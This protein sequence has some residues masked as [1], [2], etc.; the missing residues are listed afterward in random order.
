MV[1]HNLI[2]VVICSLGG[3]MEREEA[4]S[5]YIHTQ[6]TYTQPVWYNG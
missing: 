5:G 2:L 4:R 1:T 6:S 3:I